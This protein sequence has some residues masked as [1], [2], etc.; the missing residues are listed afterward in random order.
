[1]GINFALALKAV[2]RKADS[3]RFHRCVAENLQRTAKGPLR[4]PYL[5]NAGLLSL[6]AELRALEGRADEALS[7]LD[8]AS[9][10]GFRTR[11]GVGLSDFAAFDSL[12][13]DP[14]YVEIDSRLKEVT[15]REAQEVRN[16][17]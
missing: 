1:M 11:Y 8:R 9:K 15:A 3:G 16:L 17:R 6:I 12:R 4:T 10:T 5:S 2:G 7:L 13:R 14:R